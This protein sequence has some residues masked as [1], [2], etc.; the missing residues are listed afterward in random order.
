MKALVAAIVGNEGNAEFGIEAENLKR[1]T[2][3]EW[4][5][6]SEDGADYAIG[7]LIDVLR[8]VSASD[9]YVLI[10]PPFFYANDG[11]LDAWCETDNDSMG[12]WTG[13]Y[14][15]ISDKTGRELHLQIYNFS[16]K[17]GRFGGM[18]IAHGLEPLFMVQ[19]LYTLKLG[20][21]YPFPKPKREWWDANP[22]DVIREA[23]RT[24]AT[25][26]VSDVY[27]ASLQML[28]QSSFTYLRSWISLYQPLVS[29]KPN[30][31]VTE[32]IN[33]EN[34]LVRDSVDMI[35]YFA[36]SVPKVCE[37]YVKGMKTSLW[38]LR[39]QRR[40]KDIVSHGTPNQ[41]K[42]EGLGKKDE[43]QLSSRQEMPLL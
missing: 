40:W 41:R 4:F 19:L 9:M 35:W 39:G 43:N 11:F 32:K 7:L 1:K 42:W 3:Q 12:R 22:I 21:F 33:Q 18:H 36:Q 31:Q 20:D 28:K 30:A 8:L 24:G 27:I 25:P 38:Q 5:D 13:I 15:T 16:T 29:P 34:Q 14:H 2:V 23:T 17:K 6:D 26:N 37:A 10:F